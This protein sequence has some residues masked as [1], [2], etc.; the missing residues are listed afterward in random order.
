MNREQ[1]MW[2]LIEKKGERKVR[3]NARRIADKK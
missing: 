2:K 3:E 1:R